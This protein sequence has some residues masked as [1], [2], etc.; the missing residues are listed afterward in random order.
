MVV[1][2]SP[3]SPWF[4]TNTVGNFLDIRVDRKIPRNGDDVIYKIQQVYKHRPDMLA[5]DL[6][7]DAALWWVFAARNPNALKDPVFDFVPGQRIFIPKKSAIESA[8][9]T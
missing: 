9:G 4:K 3:T 7:G 8:L 2:Y 5:H 6:Y 1:Q